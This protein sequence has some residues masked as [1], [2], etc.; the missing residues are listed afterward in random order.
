MNAAEAK[1][2]VRKKKTEL[3][4]AEKKK[5]EELTKSA[6][7]NHAEL[8]QS[9]LAGVAE[10]A[11]RGNDHM[12]VSWKPSAHTEIIRTLRERGFKVTTYGGDDSFKVSWELDR[13]D[14]RSARKWPLWLHRLIVAVIFL[15]LAY[16]IGE[17]LNRTLL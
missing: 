12:F 10:A 14:I 1:D 15:G 6:L 7:H 9:C 17:V 3:E 16:F 5:H 4:A 13:D 11:R 2:L 8:V